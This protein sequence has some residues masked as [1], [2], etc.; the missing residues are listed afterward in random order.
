MADRLKDKVAIVTGGG[1][2]GP[3]GGNGKAAAVLFSR[4]DAKIVTADLD[5]SAAEEARDIIRGEGGTCI[6][7]E[8]DV[9][10]ADDIKTVVDTCRNKF[11]RVDILH[12]E[13]WRARCRWSARRRRKRV[14]SSVRSKC[15]KHVPGTSRAPWAH[16][17][18][19][20]WSDCEHLVHRVYSCNRLSMH[21]VRG[22][23]GRGQPT[24]TVD[25][26]SVL[27]TGDSRQQHLARVDAHAA[28]RTLRPVGIW[29]Q[30][31][32]DDSA[33]PRNGRPDQQCC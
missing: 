5:L 8:A 32:P 15:E 27:R 6:A 11:G 10:S 25:R 18:A 7:L 23:E 22:L 28:D 17:R 16:G 19:R 9:T 30:R 20:Q 26:Y 4:E 21:F 33:A 2:I 31:R 24:N 14:G 1:S 29:G 3:S 13:C 12:N